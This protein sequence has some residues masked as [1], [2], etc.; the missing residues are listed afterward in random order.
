VNALWDCADAKM[1][2]ALA[3]LDDTVADKRQYEI[4]YTSEVIRDLRSGAQ[5]ELPCQF[6][7]IITSGGAK[8]FDGMDLVLKNE[9]LVVDIEYDRPYKEYPNSY[10]LKLV[11]ELLELRRGQQECNPRETAMKALRNL[12]ARGVLPEADAK[13]MSAIGAG[14]SFILSES[15]RRLYTNIERE[16]IA[17]PDTPKGLTLYIDDDQ[18]NLRYLQR[19]AEIIE[20]K[21]ESNHLS[22]SPMGSNSERY[23]RA[24]QIERNTPGRGD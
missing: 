24:R 22:L 12:I 7:M 9:I 1:T 13:I 17:Q 5:P 21:G 20:Q 16:V 3:I 18:K 8:N 23:I 2:P 19:I 11:E 15:D 4:E 6:P 10:L 14:P